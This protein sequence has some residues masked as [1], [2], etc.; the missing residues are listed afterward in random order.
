MIK[1]VIKIKVE[2]DFS[3][4]VKNPY[5]DALKKQQTES[6]ETTRCESKEKK[7]LPLDKSLKTVYNEDDEATG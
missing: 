3:N 1:M 4:A 2:Y 5:A 6:E 7:D